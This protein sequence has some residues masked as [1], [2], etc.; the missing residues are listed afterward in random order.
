M[1]MLL[2]TRRALLGRA[3]EQYLLRDEFHD[4]LAAGAVNGTPATPGPGTRVVSDTN[5]RL[6]VGGGVLTLAAGISVTDHYTLD[7]IARVAGRVLL[8]RFA[9]VTTV[10]DGTLRFGYSIAAGFSV[11]GVPGYGYATTTTVRMKNGVALIGT[12]GSIGAA[13]HTFALVLSATGGYYFIKVGG[14]WQLYYMGGTDSTATL[15]PKMVDFAGSVGDNVAV[16]WIRIPVALWLPT[17][18]MYDTF[19]R[20]N[21]V[22]GSSEGVGPDGQGC[23]ILPWTAATYTIAANVALNT[24]TLGADVIVNGAFAA[25]TD[26]VHGVNWSIALG[27][28]SIALASSTD[29]TAAVPPL[30]AHFWYQVTWTNTVIAAGS[31]RAV[32]GGNVTAV[33]AAAATYTMTQVASTTA[34]VMRGVAATASIDNVICQPL[35]LPTLFA[36]VPCPTADVLV[37]LPITEGAGN[38]G[39][40]Q[41]GIVVNLDDPA[42]PQNFRVAYLNGNGGV[43]LDEYVAGVRTAKIAATAVVY[44]A[45]AKLKI[46]TQGTMLAVYY[47]EAQVGTTQTMAANI[48][49]NH[50][51]FST[52]PTPTMDNILINARGTG[53]EYQILDRWSS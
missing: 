6:S 46:V 42:N 26:W 52:Y 5:L 8:M 38:L 19:T 27:V 13:P 31:I 1:S 32:V 30:T 34:F 48:N 29:E 44:A 36:T 50:G 11:D 15:Y 17:P 33:G 49:V 20:A 25:D 23:G 47:N 9:T 16:D 35:A 53:G 3:V 10:G 22:L 18:L 37:E 51:M 2:S 43:Q 28:A 7:A 24:P 14:L 45:G 40:R 21:G 12:T 39:G 41:T 4:T